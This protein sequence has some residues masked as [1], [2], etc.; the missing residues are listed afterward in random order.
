MRA[1]WG[2][3]G[4]IVLAAALIA[5]PAAAIAQQ[6]KAKARKAPPPKVEKLACKLGTE[7]HH[8]RIAVELLGGRLQSFAY[9][10]IWKPR[11][12]S[13]HVVRD[14]AYSKWEDYGSTTT[15]Q[16]TEEKGAFLV[17]RERGK[18][19]FIF[20]DVDRMRYCGMDG[21]INGSLTIWKGRPQCA[22]QGV[23]DED[24]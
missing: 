20:R 3:L 8:A 13:I 16:L 22:L 2:I 19:H 5:A 17:D 12:C 23:M 18:Y 24:G 4:L 11:T 1:T 10:S 7:Y 9:Y 14:D 21:K 6:K 15:I